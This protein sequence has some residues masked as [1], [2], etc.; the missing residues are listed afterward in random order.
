MMTRLTNHRNSVAGLLLGVMTTS[1]FPANLVEFTETAELFPSGEIISPTTIGPLQIPCGEPVP[2]SA[3]PIPPY[4]FSFWNFGGVIFTQS[5]ISPPAPCTDFSAVAWYLGGGLGKTY[6]HVVTY[7]FSATDNKVLTP[8]PI[9]TPVTSVAPAG[10]W[11]PGQS[12]PNVVS[13]DTNS[14]NVTINAFSSLQS[15]GSFASWYLATANQALS[16]APSGPLPPPS[17]SPDLTVAAHSDYPVAIATYVNCPL[18]NCGEGRHISDPGCNIPVEGVCMSSS[19]CECAP[20][21]VPGPGRT[22]PP[23]N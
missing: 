22:C 13:T 18:P 15:Y 2:L 20:N 8:T 4:T 1:A 17:Y 7:A 9:T 16:P 23:P 10:L 14:N 11:T 19:K 5:Q 3:K 12:D 6:Q 21:C